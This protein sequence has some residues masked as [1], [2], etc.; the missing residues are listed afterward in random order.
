MG[1]KVSYLKDMEH[2]P[3]KPFRKFTNI[4]SSN[5]K[6]NVLN[7][8]NSRKSVFIVITSAL[9]PNLSASYRTNSTTVYV[10]VDG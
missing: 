2:F 4:I 10:T 5:D 7:K 1:D 9:L 3:I 8:R 6:I